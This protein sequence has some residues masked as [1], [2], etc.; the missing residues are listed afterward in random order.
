MIKQVVRYL[1]IPSLSGYCRCE[2]ENQGGEKRSST[3][4]GEKKN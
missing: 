3:K 1:E 2:N 4:E